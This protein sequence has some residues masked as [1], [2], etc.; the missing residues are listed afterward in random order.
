VAG[1]VVEQAGRDSRHERIT[2]AG[3]PIIKS[4][5]KAVKKKRKTA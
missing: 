2:F 5:I 3:R 4:G 1:G